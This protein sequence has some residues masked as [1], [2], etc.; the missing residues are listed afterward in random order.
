MASRIATRRRAFARPGTWRL[1]T[2][3]GCMERRRACLPLFLIAPLVW[4]CGAIS[5]NDD[6]PSTHPDP[7]VCNSL[8]YSRHS[9]PAKTRREPTAAKAWRPCQR[10][11]R[12]T[13]CTGVGGSTPACY[14]VADERASAR[15]LGLAADKV[16][17]QKELKR[18]SVRRTQQLTR[19]ADPMTWSTRLRAYAFRLLGLCPVVSG[20]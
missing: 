20:L 2:Q 1:P 13:R 12:R 18:R 3:A 6:E 14:R 9:S 16:A 7:A 19:R 8:G 4:A 17:R 15:K 10:Y 5:V 11:L